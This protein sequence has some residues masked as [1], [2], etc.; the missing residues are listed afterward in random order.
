MAV[1]SMCVFFQASTSRKED[2][3]IV[4]VRMLTLE[5]ATF[6]FQLLVIGKLLRLPAMLTA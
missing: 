5:V 2:L 3:I 6:F 1:R 4:I